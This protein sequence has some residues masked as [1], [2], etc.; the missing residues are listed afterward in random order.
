MK[1]EEKRNDIRKI[2][3]TLLRRTIFLMII[4]G[5]VMF[6]PLLWKLWDIQITNHDYYQQ[7]ALKQ[8]TGDDV[9]E[10]QRGKIY[11]SNG[12][13]LAMS[14]KVH[15]VVLSPKAVVDLQAKY[16]KEVEDAEAGEG[17]FPTR[18]EPTNDLI[19]SG[20]SAILNVDTSDIYKTL[21]KTWRQYEVV[22][23]EVDDEV[24][25]QVDAFIEENQLRTGI[26]LEETTMRYYPSSSLASH[27]IGFVNDNGGA[28]GLEA[29]YDDIL[30]GEAGRSVYI[31]NARKTEII[32]DYSKHISAIDGSDLHLTLDTKIQS[33]LENALAEGIELYD[34]QYG[35][36]AIAMDPNTGAILGF[37]SSNQYDLN[38]PSIIADSIKVNEL[39][40]LKTTISSEEYEKALN[41]ARQE[42]WRSKALSDTYEPGSTFK[43]L[44]LAAALEEGVVN[45]SDTFYCPGYAIVPGDTIDCNET[46]GHGHQTLAEAVKN[47]CNPAF[48]EIGRRLG[49][50]KFYDYIE[51]YNLI[52]STGVDIPGEPYNTLI[53]PREEFTSE[54]GITSL[55]TAS[56]GQRFNITPLQLL[57]GFAATINGGH[58][59]EPYVVESAIDNFGTTTYRHEITEIR[60]V[61]SASTSQRVRT[62]LESVVNGGTGKNAYEAGYRIGGKT[63]TSETLSEDKHNI[64]SF[65]GFAP[66]NDPQ[67]IV[68]LA[69]DG[70]KPS[71]NNSEK[72][73]GGYFI[74]GGNMAAPIAGD[75]IANILDYMG[76]GKQYTPEELSGADT[77]VPKLVGHYADYAQT[78]VNRAGL[79]YCFVGEGDVVTGQIPAQGVYIPGNSQV[80]LYLGNE[81]VPTDKIPVP[82]VIGLAPEIVQST[83]TNAGLYL[84]A[85][86]AVE[87]YVSS[88]KAIDQSI[89][90]GTMVD[91]GTVIEVRFM[92]DSV[93]DY[94]SG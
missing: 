19:A 47:S 67:V 4:F 54:V 6:I 13:L 90:A 75:L 24:A 89:E 84:R 93:H 77:M 35:G 74:S 15:N 8:Q 72:T 63:G 23:A 51:S 81:E 87:Y 79:T 65:V 56:F 78:L 21:A 26:F 88:N 50:D 85:T 33:L 41:L 37:A 59:Y 55:A 82:D 28:Y 83:L 68:L 31:R 69:Y 43:A 92:D 22:K 7:L 17:A 11:D 2:N 29:M 39:E 70:P 18:P 73:E 27:V 38:N 86:G 14:I 5:I 76:V 42:Q 49:A 30:S 66:A 12:S 60:Q 9:L 45:E 94:T 52:G 34:I 91:R 40:L 61:V 44:V 62:I 57:S 3:N 53:W 58:L 46:D 36:F 25:E 20:L 64:V 1:G 48:I 16:A 71:A 10:A 80:L 32:T